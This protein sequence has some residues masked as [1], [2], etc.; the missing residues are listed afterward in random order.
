MSHNIRLTIE[1]NGTDYAGWQFQPN[2]PT[3]QGEL[4]SAL[5]KVLGKEPSLFGCGRTDA[6]VSARN[7]VANFLTDANLPIEKIPLALNSY[8]PDDIFVK[9]AE[10]V[11]LDFHSRYSAKSKTYC[12]YIVLGR[13]PIRRHHAWEFYHSLDINRL[14]LVANLFLGRKDFNPFCH[15]RERQG[16]CWITSIRIKKSRD[17]IKITVAGDR[18][19][20]KMV[21]R[22]VGAM[23]AYAS[24]RITQQDIKNALKGKKYRSFQTAPGHGLILE[25]VRY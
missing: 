17:E 19:L 1:F 20:Y 18:F 11:P 3:I 9:K 8:L 15:T 14:K 22:I 6:G 5:K 4:Q 13:S 23:V 25:S 21:R 2:Q 7:Y 16:V 10:V 24:R 12:Y